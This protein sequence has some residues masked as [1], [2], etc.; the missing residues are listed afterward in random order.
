[1]VDGE[2]VIES[3]GELSFEALQMR[4]H[5]AESRIRKLSS[6]TPAKFILFDMLAN[7][8]W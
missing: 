8:R 6:E 5:P 7:S 1:M 4:L 2:I 3:D